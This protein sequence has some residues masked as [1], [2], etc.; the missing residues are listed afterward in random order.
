MS[1]APPAIEV[2]PATSREVV[3]RSARAAAISEALREVSRRV[4][5]T[6]HVFI[7]TV[8]AQRRWQYA[9]LPIVVGGFI[10]FVALPSLISGAYLAFMAS[11]QYA[12]EA[13]FA[14]RGGE[15]TLMESLGGLAALKNVQDSLIV[16][17]YVQSRGIVEEL[18]ASLSL[19]QIY[20]R[21][22]VDLLSRFNSKKPIEDL[23]HYWQSRVDVTI[24][25]MSGIITVVARAF[26]PQDALNIGNAIIASSER[27]V[28][29][30]SERSRRDTLRQA[31][32]ELDRAE[33]NLK[34]KLRAMRQLR[35]TEHLVD[36]NR[37]AELMTKMY[38]DLR[39]ELI[40]LEQEYN[41]QKQSVLPSAPQLRVLQARINAMRDQLQKLA[42]Q[43][44]RGASTTVSAAGQPALSESMARFERQKL[45]HQ[46]A[47][48]QY[49]AAA[50]AFERARVEMSTQEVYLATIL[51]PV[52]A[53]DA[54]Y[55]KRVWIFS[56]VLFSSLLLWGF[57]VG[58]AV[59]IRNHIAI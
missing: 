31:K 49:L 39:L 59:L 24:D 5:R 16:Y 4:R 6:G 36:A 52:L 15:R 13:R 58:L 21:A 22:G 23:V 46:L 51:R 54:I 26:S 11:D 18:D 40:Q 33:A 47:E 28:N 30:L 8:P 27:L 14:V 53:Q 37:S 43:I 19:R 12:A 34:A 57:V 35:D 38:S 42:G 7:P 50:G 3:A 44:T 25:Q 1:K 56:V 41:V 9:L 20:S 48:Q 45:E 55:P 17:E 29:E 2:A 10:V 32:S